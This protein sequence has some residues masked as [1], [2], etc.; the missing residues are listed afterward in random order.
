MTLS[1]FVKKFQH[2]PVEDTWL[3]NGLRILRD[4]M[5]NKRVDTQGGF[6]RLAGGGGG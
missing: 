1:R 2:K 4:F 5:K 3:P 6:S